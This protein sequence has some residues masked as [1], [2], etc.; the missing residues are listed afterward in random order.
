[1]NSHVK[2]SDQYHEPRSRGRDPAARPAV[3]AADVDLFQAPAGVRIDVE[4]VEEGL[5]DAVVAHRPAPENLLAQAALPR[6]GQWALALELVVGD[7]LLP[8]MLGI[9]EDHWPLGRQVVV[10]RPQSGLFGLDGPGGQGRDLPCQAAQH[11]PLGR[12]NRVAFHL[13]RHRYVAGCIGHSLLQSK[14]F[15]SIKYAC[16]LH[17]I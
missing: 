10:Q 3:L 16:H 17:I 14:L 5:D 4:E 15:L 6:A 7:D 1:M 9:A 2:P 11:L 13:R 12:G 8:A